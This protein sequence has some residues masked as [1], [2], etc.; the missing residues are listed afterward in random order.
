VKRLAAAV[1][2]L[3]EVTAYAQ[4]GTVA[5][6]APLASGAVSFSVPGVKAGLKGIPFAAE[7][8][9]E[10]TRTL[11][12]GTHISGTT[13]GGVY[14]DSEGRTRREFAQPAGENDVRIVSITD[15]VH[16]VFIHFIIG[17]ATTASTEGYKVATVTPMHSSSPPLSTAT[18]GALAPGNGTSGSTTSG[19]V[20]ERP[21]R[22][23]PPSRE[24]LGIQEMEGLSVR[25]TR[26]T[27]TIEAGK[28][29]NDQPI[30]IVTESWYSKDLQEVLLSETDDPRSG[31]STAK[32]VNIQRDEPD[33][34][35]FQVP[36]D[37]TVK[38]Q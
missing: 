25:G 14:R 7:T 1:V 4:V 33:P 21:S 23:A 36:P 8:V 27:R 30:V 38:E 12:D 24:D 35:L 13:H 31:H 18:A 34:A 20:G 19:G 15:P 37:Y 26:T 10:T 3:L 29:G 17:N 6:R 9:S 28:I 11:A 5:R 32:L 2:L 16:Q 22:P